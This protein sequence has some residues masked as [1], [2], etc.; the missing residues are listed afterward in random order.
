[1]EEDENDSKPATLK[2]TGRPS[3]RNCL[4]EQCVTKKWTKQ[5]ECRVVATA[6]NLFCDPRHPI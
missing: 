1:M 4:Q 5:V 6:K 3:K 2:D